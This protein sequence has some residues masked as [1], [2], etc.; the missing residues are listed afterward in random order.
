MKL[1][2]HTETIENVRLAKQTF[3]LRKLSQCKE[4]QD[5][6]AL[7]LEYDLKMSQIENGDI[8]TKI[9]ELERQLHKSQVEVTL[10]NSQI[11][12]SQNR[13]VNGDQQV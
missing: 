1:L 10:L 8:S 12:D 6:K 13:L 2:Q 9:S 11:E 5:K 3:D 7:A 4:K